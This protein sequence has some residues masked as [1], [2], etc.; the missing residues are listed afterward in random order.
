M[1]IDRDTKAEYEVTGDV[2][3]HNDYTD[4]KK[5][6]EVAAGQ[7]FTIILGANHTTGYRWELSGSI[8]KNIVDLVG[9]EYKASDTPKVGSGGREVWF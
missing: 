4:P 2:T 8:D 9:S 3:A 6:I 7:K 1:G 5:P